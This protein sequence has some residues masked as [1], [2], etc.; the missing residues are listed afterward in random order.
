MSMYVRMCVRACIRSL[1]ESVYVRAFNK[2][3]R[4]SSSVQYFTKTNQIQ[5]K[6]LTNGY[7]KFKLLS[8]RLKSPIQ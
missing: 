2:F 1:C 4:Q 5:Y 6:V 7:K 3:D 8:F